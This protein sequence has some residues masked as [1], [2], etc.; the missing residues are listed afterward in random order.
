MPLLPTF[1]A[2]PA[3]AGALGVLLLSVAACAAHP[4][5]GAPDVATLQSPGP[6][7]ASS[8][9]PASQRPVL[10]P[11][12][13][14]A[15]IVALQ[16]AYSGCLA[17]HGVPVTGAAGANEV[18]K[19]TVD[20]SLPQYA[21]ART[22]CAAKEPESWRDVVARTDPQYADRVRAE[23]RCLTDQGIKA[24]LRG[25]PPYVVFTD[26]RQV[27]RAMDL[28][29]ECERKAFGDAMQQFNDK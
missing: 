22:A 12:M 17:E 27:G 13:T 7:R 9:A 20:L 2:T 24:E 25:Q 1:R 10:R 15:E 4:A 16:N 6:V 8:A 18:R 28:E 3:R 19:P 29:P 23:L 5:G 11:D 21:A 26:D 14:D